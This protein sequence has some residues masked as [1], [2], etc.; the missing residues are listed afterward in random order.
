MHKSTAT[1][2]ANFMGYIINYHGRA[3][4][5]WWASNSSCWLVYSPCMNNSTMVEWP[6]CMVSQAHMTGHSNWKQHNMDGLVQDCSISIAIAM[7]ILQSCSQPLKY[8]IVLLVH[9]VFVENEA[10]LCLYYFM[11]QSCLKILENVNNMSSH[12]WLHRCFSS[13]YSNSYEHPT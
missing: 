13:S 11:I 3:T 2:F 9:V 8:K 10:F 1:P 7:E 6:I 12:W 4:C 5:F